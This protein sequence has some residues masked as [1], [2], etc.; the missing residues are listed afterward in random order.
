M[1]ELDLPADQVAEIT[2][3]ANPTPYAI[4]HTRTAL[5]VGRA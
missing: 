3:P 1:E 5:L 2:A 4:K